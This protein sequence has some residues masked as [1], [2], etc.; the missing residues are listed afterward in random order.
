[1]KNM[2]E[3]GITLTTLI[4]TVI[5]LLILAA[6][7]ISTLGPNGFVAKAEEAKKQAQIDE[8]KEIVGASAVQSAGANRYGNIEKEE[9]AIYVE[10][11]AGNRDVE[12]IEDANK[13]YVN[14]KDTERYYEVGDEGEVSN[15]IIKEEIEYAG[16]IT[17]GGTLDGSVD[18]PYEIWCI[19][20]LVAF[21]IMSNGG[22][23]ELGLASNTFTDKY[24][25][26]MRTLDF[27]SIFSYN[28]HMSTKYGDLNADGA[29]DTIKTELTKTAEGCV[30]FTPIKSFKGYFDGKGNEIQNIYINRGAAAGLFAVASGQVKEIKNIGVTGEIISI[31]G[32]AAGIV[33]C[34]SGGGGYLA[35]AIE[36]C[37]NKANV[38]VTETGGYVA[39]VCGG[40]S[41]T[42]IRDC[43][44]I[45]I[46]TN[47][48]TNT[49]MTG[50]IAAG[51]GHTIENCYNT[52]NIV[53]YTG[54]TGGIASGHGNSKATIKNCYN[55]GNI[56]GG[57]A[58]GILGVNGALV[59]NCY[60]TGNVTGIGNSYA[61]GITTDAT[62]IKNCY[63]T[64][65]IKDN[66]IGG[67]CWSL[68]GKV[69]N[70]YNLGTVT[71]NRGG[72][73]AGINETSGTEI[74]NCFNIAD[75]SCANYDGYS[76]RNSRKKY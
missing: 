43:Y 3:K 4:I 66:Y 24:V 74:S 48:R 7:G 64:G 60:N 26:L 68:K 59:E 56:Q 65:N 44:N 17:K 11:N 39:G 10:K 42:V 19:E 8:E 53:S 46:I 20:D 5:I 55:T 25:L 45:G 41:D 70:C 69:I 31:N 52:G 9:L 76:G 16:D 75:V 51:F 22:N 50:G 1:M 38:T 36:N 18:K 6:V 72:G 12:V 73:I 32:N 2:N 13:I 34:T 63:N 71:G 15:P 40:G 35:K 61:S 21:S 29:T 62:E 33:A 57:A 27:N 23:T 37:W 28:D 49:G 67:I 58:G 30:G 14:F 54:Y 47:N